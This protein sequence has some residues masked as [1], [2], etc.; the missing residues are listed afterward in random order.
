MLKPLVSLV[1]LVA[2]LGMAAPAQAHHGQ[3]S[4]A[5]P[6]EDPKDPDP[7]ACD[8]PPEPVPA[9]IAIEIGDNF[10]C[11]GGSSASHTVDAVLVRVTIHYCKPSIGP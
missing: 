4:H 10:E 5:P 6:P 8:P 11:V 3:G 9:P 2:V 1:A 7:C